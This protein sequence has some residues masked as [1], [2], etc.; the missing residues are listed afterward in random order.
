[1]SFS[2]NHTIGGSLTFLLPG[3]FKTHTRRKKE[4]RKLCYRGEEVLGASHSIVVASS[5]H[6]TIGGPHFF[7]SPRSL[8]IKRYLEEFG[9]GVG[10][11]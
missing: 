1:M 2:N 4:Q 3:S 5:I 9:W 7:Q 10:R 11:D 8:K 6:H